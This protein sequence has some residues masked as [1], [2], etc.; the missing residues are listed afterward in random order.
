MT[1]SSNLTSNSFNKSNST[2]HVDV[3]LMR[4][5]KLIYGK[6]CLVHIVHLETTTMDYN[7]NGIHRNNTLCFNTVGWDAKNMSC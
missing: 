1:W 7:K 4:S 2:S 6:Y 5:K 3:I